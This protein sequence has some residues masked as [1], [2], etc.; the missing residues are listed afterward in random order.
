MSFG[1]RVPQRGLKT[2]SPVTRCLRVLA[3]VAL[4]AGLVIAPV[5]A[6]GRPIAAVTP[7]PGLTIEA[8]VL[9]DGHAR[10]GSWMAIDVR[11]KNDGPPIVGELRLTG[12]T[13]GRTRFGTL[14]EAPTQSD[15]THRLYVQ[16][17]GF[18]RELEISLVSGA[19]TIATT[20]A[21]FA[22]HEGT[23][24]I[25][26]IV[27]E[28]P[29]DVIGDLDLLPNMNNVKPL[30]VGLDIAD[31]P[32]RVEAWG[33]LDRLIW[34][35]MDSAQLGSDQIAALRGWVAGGGRLVIVGGTAGPAS[36]SAFPDDLLPYRPTTTTDVA[37]SSLVALLGEL[38]KDATDLPALSGELAGG[39]ALATVG[40]QTVAA[41]LP[42]GTGAVS[43][44]G[45][46][47]TAKWI[48][49][50]RMAEGLWRRLIPTRSAGG[51]AMGDDSQIVQAASQ[52][53]TLALPPV[54]GLIALLGGY[55]LLIG[56][57]NYLVLR[58]FDKREW[59]WVTMPA[60]IV[61][62]AIG[63]YGFGS[64]LRG[65]DII[66]NE[67]A[68]VRGAPGATE[69]LAQAYLGVFSP[70]RGSY[71]VRVPGGA[72]LSSPING[73]FIGNGTTASLD[74]LQGDPSRVRDLGV[75]FGSLRTIRAESAV[76]VPLVQADLRLV[77]GRLQGTVTNASD[78]TL[79]AP[80]VVLGGTVAKL[81][82]LAPGQS[83]SVDVALQ[84]VQMGQQL[85]DKIVGQVFFG[86]PRQ[87]GGEAGARQYARHTIIDQLTFDPN[88][89][90]TGQL[91]ADGAVVLAWSDRE[92]LTVEI[93]GQQARRTGN[94]LWFLPAD[95]KVSGK[96]TFRQDLLRS[97][98]VSSDAAFFNK[99]PFSIG[100]G[101]GSAELSYRPISFD[102]TIDATQLA[103]GFNF[104]EFGLPG[105]EPK[106][107]EP[108]PAI[109]VT[110]GN[111][112]VEGC[113]QPQFDGLPEVEL[114]D[115]TTG[116]WRRL[117]HLAGGSRYAVAEPGDYVD[118]ATGTVLVRFVNDFS[119]GVNFMLDLSITGN[120]K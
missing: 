10:V 115:L 74:V 52:L 107:V 53:P 55:I 35:D 7:P 58:H 116:T 5:E 72:L 80:A 46:D 83:A 32:N 38:P 103:I 112:P 111:P 61:A 101:R 18:G 39:R 64:L 1:V 16:P 44:V 63:A 49:G 21:A 102:G 67:V 81:A 75:G 34:Q 77:E 47:P 19:S 84:A 110:C 70:T 22:I 104:G 100:F 71:Q 45:F 25:V 42:Y 40:G 114:Y 62:F 109:P 92:L 82:D 65:S 97:T 73:D 90:F 41:E 96:T 79:Q 120:V 117:P 98:V 87:G 29:G 105:A 60:L 50:T 89:G 76:T 113:V 30:T 56:P 36:L 6:S 78:E 31:L 15:K 118:P 51:G 106:P 27:A 33:V 12:G 86:D 119:D 17:P 14:I 68:I 3:A 4:V 11:L 9:L 94:V 88:W 59:A 37:P 66:V 13:Q 57:I 108:L 2:A 69:G 8:T 43:I 28:R 99:D 48:T 26:G 91:P 93:E 23:Q 85:S 54:N 20:K 24:M 95:I